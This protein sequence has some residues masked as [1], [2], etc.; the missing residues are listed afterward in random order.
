[1]ISKRV[2]KKNESWERLKM[3]FKIFTTDITQFAFILF[4]FL[5]LIFNFFFFFLVMRRNYLQ[6]VASIYH[7]ILIFF[8]KIYLYVDTISLLVDIMTI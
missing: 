1:M 2:K 5:F 4:F 8:K 3:E 7:V 6:G